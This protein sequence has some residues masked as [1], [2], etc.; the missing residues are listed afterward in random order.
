MRRYKH[1]K[2]IR[3]WILEKLY[4][5]YLENPTEMLGP[6]DFLGTELVDKK[7]LAS[8]IHYLYDKELVELITGYNPPLFVATRITPKGID[9]VENPHDFDLLFPA[10]PAGIEDETAELLEIMEQLVV[11]ADLTPLEGDVRKCLLRDIQYLRDEFARPAQRWRRNVIMQ[12]IQWIEDSLG[13]L[14]RDE[15]MPSLRLMQ[16][17]IRKLLP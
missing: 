9:L 1:P 13:S 7:Q 16:E 14:D 8:N 11:E 4:E 3:R 2:A 6:E 15:F 12:V 17:Q 5:R 10:Y